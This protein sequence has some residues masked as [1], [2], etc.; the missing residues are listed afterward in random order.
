MQC[1]LD[2]TASFDH[3]LHSMVSWWVNLLWDQFR[4][5]RLLRWYLY[6]LFDCL[7]SWNRCVYRKWK[8]G[9][10]DRQKTNIFHLILLDCYFWN[11]L[12]FVCNW[13]N[14]SWRVCLTIVCK[15]RCIWRY[16]Y[17]LPS[18]RLTIPDI[19]KRKHNGYHKLFCTIRMYFSSFWRVIF[20]LV[21]FVAVCL[22]GGDLRLTCIKARRD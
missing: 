13:V 11:C 19:C 12:Y 7:W 6:K 9:W 17:G 18:T 5:E 8:A 21:V 20:R 16:K 10:S 15:I 3:F 2:S 22:S 14:L 1:W 4:C